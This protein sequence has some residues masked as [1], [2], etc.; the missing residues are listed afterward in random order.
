MQSSKWCHG[1]ERPIESYLPEDIA[2]LLDSKDGEEETSDFQLESSDILTPVKTTKVSST[3]SAAKTIDD[4][5]R[6]SQKETS[7]L[8]RRPPFYVLQQV[9]TMS[10]GMEFANRPNW[11]HVV[12]T[13]VWTGDFGRAAREGYVI[14]SRLRL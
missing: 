7:H 3:L 6:L 13:G 9:P 4:G 12:G 8:S 10:R 14:H 1:T 5:C 2:K 11:R